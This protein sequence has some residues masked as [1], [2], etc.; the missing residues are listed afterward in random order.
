M[1]WGRIR[2]AGTGLGHAFGQLREPLFGNNPEDV[3]L[4]EGYEEAQAELDRLREMRASQLAAAQAARAAGRRTDIGQSIEEAGQRAGRDAA[5]QSMARAR[6]SVAG[7]RGLGAL[8]LRRAALGA[9][10]QAAAQAQGGIL[11]G[12]NQRADVA[13]L[14]R[15]ESLFR[16]VVGMNQQAAQAA[17]IEEQLRAAGVDPGLFPTIMGVLGTAA[18]G[19][20]GGGQGAQIGG[21]LG[22]GLGDITSPYLR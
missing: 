7:A 10:Q 5:Q 4:P 3:E 11:E 16:D 1:V 17:L 2:E 13:D 9:G 6:G 8:G 14:Q 22:V 21:Q 15:E 19:Y 18:G 20:F 12:A